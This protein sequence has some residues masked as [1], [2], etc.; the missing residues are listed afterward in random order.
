M[1]EVTID[2]LS[3][4]LEQG[5]P[6]VDVREAG[7]YAEGHV[8]GVVHIPMGQLPA[9]VDELRR[10]QPVLV[11]CASGNRSSAMTDYLASAGFDAASVSGGTTAWAC[12]G[13]PIEKD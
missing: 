5:L 2:D 1:R 11:I 6:V 8:P 3:R 10:E 9:R 12:A 13:R 4:A 7:E